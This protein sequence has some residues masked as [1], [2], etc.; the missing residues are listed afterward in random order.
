MPCEVLRLIYIIWSDEKSRGSCGG[1]EGEVEEVEE[2]EDK[3][4]TAR[5]SAPFDA[6][7]RLAAA[8]SAAALR[9][10][11]LF[12]GCLTAFSGPGDG[13][14]SSSGVDVD[15]DADWDVD[16]DGGGRCSSAWLDCAS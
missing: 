11:N 6:P 14:G 2:V 1:A 3:P 9:P 12:L 13:A 15:V 5:P 8:P 4:W 16:A 7:S 10:T